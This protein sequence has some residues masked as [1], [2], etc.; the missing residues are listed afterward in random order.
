MTYRET[1]HAD[2]SLSPFVNGHS[3]KR[4]AFLVVE[5]LAF[6]LCWRRLHTANKDST[7]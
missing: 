2:L 7:R 5:E 1:H 4:P 3:E 6:D